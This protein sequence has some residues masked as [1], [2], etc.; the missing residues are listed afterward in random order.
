MRK[1]VVNPGPVEVSSRVLRALGS[2]TMYHYDPEF[3]EIFRETQE[4]IREIF[5]TDYDVVIM[6]GEAL[7]PLEAA[8]AGIVRPGVKCL[9]L[10]SGFFGEGY[11]GFLTKYGG[12]VVEVTTE[13][14][15]VVNSKEVEKVL[16]REGD[17]K[18]VSMLHCETPSGTINRIEEICP[19]AKDHGAITIVDAVSSFGG[20]ELLPDEWGIDICI[21]GSQKC[22]A[23]SPGLGMV[24]VSPD[25]WEALEK[26]EN[27]LRG[28]Y[29]SLL[30]W[31]DVWLSGDRFP[32]T[33]SVNEIY[34]LRVAS[35]MVLEEGLEKVFKRYKRVGRASR[36][37]IKAMGMEIYQK[38]EATASD[39]VT[40]VKAPHGIS[41][42]E[43]TTRCLEKYGVSISG[44][45]GVQS[46]ELLR[47][48][49]MG[50]TAQL[51]VLLMSLAVLGKSL[52]D[53]GCKV[54]V[55]Y[56]IDQAISAY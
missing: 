47:L 52:K 53:L 23:S 49:H 50:P 8:A 21:A 42:T 35:A 43:V 38:D 46:E 44:G 29:M 37:G 34:A 7:L 25:A 19:I 6:Q 40:V 14:N 5:Q 17:V 32:Y 41:S 26:V 56:G 10:V 24:S 16:E 54:E 27:P 31:K 28:S 36:A 2:P 9:N 22:L 18:V 30:D 33:P 51:S 13:Y 4:N 12:E 55:G 1:F 48:G 11:K 15:D 45:M 3:K 39:T 20:M